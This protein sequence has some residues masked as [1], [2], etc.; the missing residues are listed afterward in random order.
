MEDR[1]SRSGEDGTRTPPYYSDEEVDTAFR[2]L[3][4]T[5]RKLELLALVARRGSVLARSGW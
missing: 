3:E 1:C 4:G 5:D 2:A